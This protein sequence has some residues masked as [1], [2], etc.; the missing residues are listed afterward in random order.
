MYARL[1]F[2]KLEQ[3]IFYQGQKATQIITQNKIPTRNH[4]GE[5]LFND[6]FST[7]QIVH[8]VS[9]QQIVNSLNCVLPFL[10]ARAVNKLLINIQLFST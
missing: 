5:N 3:I 10:V 7:L 8:Y 9:K 1:N 6:N 4:Q 2:T